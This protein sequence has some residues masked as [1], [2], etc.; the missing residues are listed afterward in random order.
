MKLMTSPHEIPLP[1]NLVRSLLSLQSICRKKVNGKDL[2]DDKELLSFFNSVKSSLENYQQHYRIPELAQLI[3]VLPPV[4]SF[5]RERPSTHAVQ[6]IFYIVLVPCLFLS[7]F[8][9]LTGIVLV[10]LLVA[11]YYLLNIVRLRERKRIHEKLQRISEICD[12]VAMLIRN[13]ETYQ[14]PTS[15]KT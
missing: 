13:N 2:V 1:E 6:L 14:P 15:E 4:N 11:A 12:G 7:I 10:A 8:F 3:E 5:E 9:P